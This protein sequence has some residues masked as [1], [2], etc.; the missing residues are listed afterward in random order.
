MGSRE[1]K[2]REGGSRGSQCNGRSVGTRKTLHSNVVF[3]EKV[4]RS[5]RIQHQRP[6][7]DQEIQHEGKTWASM[8]SIEDHV[9]SN[10][11]LGRAHGKEMLLHCC[12]A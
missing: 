6:D 1:K 8:V 10:A 12:T 4:E 7:F 5:E 3:F 9:K 11:A 2:R